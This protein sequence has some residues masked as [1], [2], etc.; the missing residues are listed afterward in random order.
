MNTP[1]SE[2][3]EPELEERLRRGLALLAEQTPPPQVRSQ[4]RL[5]TV[6][7][8]A[9]IAIAAAVTGVVVTQAGDGGK[10]VARATHPPSVPV[11]S[12]P[13]VQSAPP[14]IGSGVS[15][16]LHKLVAESPRIVIGTVT[17]VDHFGPSDA[18]GGLPYV[19]ANLNVDRT[20]KGPADATVVAFDYDYGNT[21]S[22]DSPSGATFTVGMRV[23]LF[24][25]D[26]TGTVHEDIAPRHWQVTG[27]GQ[28]EY[29]MTGN[30]P[31]ASFTI[32][33]VEKAVQ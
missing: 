24:L 7:A 6:G 21:I 1:D 32:G 5:V 29:R 25:S 3:L 27:G 28:G 9:G 12:T 13:P 11:H 17:S 4:R 22:S 23:L 30:E 20:L 10:P 16:D 2:M 26:S 33:D 8:A 31:E 15:Y 14:P 19:L 18:S